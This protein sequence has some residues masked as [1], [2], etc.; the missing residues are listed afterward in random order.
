MIC[1]T[2]I[3]LSLSAKSR[4]QTIIMRHTPKPAQWAILIVVL[5]MVIAISG[6]SSHNTLSTTPL[7]PTT[8]PIGLPGDPTIT[9]QNLVFNPPNMPVPKGT[10]VTWVNQDSTN[11]QIVNDATGTIAK[12]ALFTSGSLPTGAS[13]SFKFYN[14]GTY[15]YHCSIHPSMKGIVTVT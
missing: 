1:D 14:S 12:G 6:C 15:P 11:H 3:L 7:T 4:Y 9:I 10:T 2:Q 8:T 5:V 13:Y